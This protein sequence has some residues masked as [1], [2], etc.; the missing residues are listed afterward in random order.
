MMIA[1]IILGIV[2]L[3]FGAVLVVGPPYV[4]TLSRQVETA[5][6]LLSLKPGQTLLELGSGDGKVMKAAA[7]RGLKVVGIELNPF[8]VIISRIRCWKYRK[9]VTIIWDDLWRARW[10]QADGIFTFMLQRQMERLDK[11][12]DLWHEKPVKLASFAFH[13]P[14]RPPKS[15][16]NGIFLYEYKKKSVLK[17]KKSS[18]TIEALA[19]KAVAKAT[20]S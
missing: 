17:S 4:P 19:A 8:L 11:R 1:L 16:Y 13:I 20:A 18:K 3:V 6:D 14:D 2:I 7:E 9:Q 10:P 12:I 5:L 15:K